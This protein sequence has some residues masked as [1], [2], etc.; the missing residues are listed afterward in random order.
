MTNVDPSSRVGRFIFDRV[1]AERPFNAGVVMNQLDPPTIADE[2]APQY[3]AGDME[4]ARR[5]GFDEGFH[6]GREEGRA[7]GVQMALSEAEAKTNAAFSV[8]AENL[9]DLARRHEEAYHA[10][11]HDCERLMHVILERLLPELV[12]RGG[13]E[14]ILGV[15]RTALSIACND[16]VVE[17]RVPHDVVEGIKPRIVRLARDVGFRGRVDLLGDSYLTEGMVRVRWL[18]GG[19][20]RDPDQMLTE[21]SAIVARMLDRGDSQSNSPTEE[22]VVTIEDQATESMRS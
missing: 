9:A 7:E 5:Q 17:V 22:T 1:F 16:P 2:P 15:V 6:Q 14:E 19:A 10:L 12:H 13:A 21:V 11:A 3:S 8:L 4:A 20:Q 18:H